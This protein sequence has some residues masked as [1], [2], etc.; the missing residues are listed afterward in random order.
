MHAASTDQIN[1]LQF[2]A[3]HEDELP[4]MSRF[5]ARILPSAAC[6]TDSERF[7]KV[8]KAVCSDHRASLAGD[9]INMCASMHEWLTDK[10]LYTDKKGH[11]RDG[12]SNRFANLSVD[13]EVLSPTELSDDDEDE[14]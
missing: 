8:T 6:S 14:E 4:L 9:T 3:D 10:Y 1:N 2:W 11:R 13:L 12:V 7:F 5:A